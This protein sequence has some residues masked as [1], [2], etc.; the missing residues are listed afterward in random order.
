MTT[1]D[2]SDVVGNASTQSEKIS[3]RGRRYFLLLIEVI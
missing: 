2:F 1:D 3:T